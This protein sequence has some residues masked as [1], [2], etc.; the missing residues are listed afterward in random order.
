MFNVGYAR[1]L[2]KVNQF[3]RTGLQLSYIF[4]H[5]DR[6]WADIRKGEFPWGYWLLFRSLSHEVK[7]PK[8]CI[9]QT[10]PTPHHFSVNHNRFQRCDP[11][12]SECQLSFYG[13]KMQ[14]S[15]Q[16]NTVLYG[17]QRVI[18]SLMVALNPNKDM[19]LCLNGAAASQQ[20]RDRRNLT[21]TITH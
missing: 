18:T 11:S 21:P 10:T 19:Q 14:S 9:R 16:H 13:L 12:Y 15:N 5:Q 2:V 4:F 20:K 3:S 1:S 6:S 7:P 8:H 17:Q